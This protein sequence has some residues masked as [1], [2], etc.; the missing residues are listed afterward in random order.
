MGPERSVYFTGP[1][2]R[3][4]LQAQNLI[5]FMDIADTV[6]DETWRYHADRSDFSHWLR[7]AIADRELAD[8]VGAV[9]ASQ[10]ISTCERRRQLRDAIE[11]RYT[12]PSEAATPQCT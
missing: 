5:A 4:H 9:E 7:D 2:G 12:S 3:H 1:E 8:H 6:D 11:Q 10:Q